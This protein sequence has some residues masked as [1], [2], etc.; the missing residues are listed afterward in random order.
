MIRQI[1]YLRALAAL[2]VVWYHAGGQIP[3]L[4]PFVTYEF[5]QYGVDLFFVISGFIMLVTT[6][7]KPIGSAEFLVNRIKRIVPLYWAATLLLVGCAIVAPALFTRLKWDGASLVKSLL[8][9]PYESLSLPGR[10]LPLLVPGWSLNTEMFFYV[11]FAALLLVGRNWRVP[12]MVGTLSALVV[13]GVIWHP[14]GAVSQSYT[15]PRL[16]E[17]AVGMVLGRLWVMKKHPR[18]D[19]GNRLLLALGDASYSIYLSHMFTLTGLRLVWGRLPIPA[20]F[21]TSVVFMAFCLIGCAVA[22]WICY[23]LVERPITKWIAKR[24]LVIRIEVLGEKA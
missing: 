5:G 18:R 19:G 22:G 11:L 13:G 3:S 9:V 14:T 4:E 20:N 2:M 1:Q 15:D 6:W 12:L 24:R 7:D 17:F 10:A 21:V 23:R 8:F 16:L